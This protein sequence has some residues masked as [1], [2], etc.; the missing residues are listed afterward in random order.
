MTVSIPTRTRVLAAVVVPALLL[1]TG[2]CSGD[3]GGGDSPTD[4]LAAAKKTL[5]DTS[6]VKIAL[7]TPKLPD[8][9]DGVVDASG[10][11][12][13]APAFDGQIKVVVNSLNVDVPVVAVQGAVYAKLPF[14]T[15][16]AEID[17]G[18]YGAP[19][20]ADLMDP[21]HGISGWLTDLQDPAEGDQVRQGDQVLTTY[22]GTL[23]GTSVAEVIPSADKK[24]EFDASFRLDDHD[25]LV[26]AE[27]TGPFYDKKGDVDYTITLS[28]YGTKKDITKP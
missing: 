6:G 28:D 16:F 13:H 4:A 14:T 9:I 25:Q 3:G 21:E 18:D 26:S 15:K 1:A 20:P 5:D 27:V 8:G 7:T 17:P 24:A 2:G 22:S 23:P 12:T 19:D 11:G 10:V